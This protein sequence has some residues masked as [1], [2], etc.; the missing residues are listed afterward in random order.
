MII[1]LL[2]I[3]LLGVVDSTVNFTQEH[4]L[5][6]ALPD[7]SRATERKESSTQGVFRGRGMI[8]NVRIRA[9]GSYAY[10]SGESG[11]G[12]FYRQYTDGNL[13]SWVETAQLKPDDLPAD[14]NTLDAEGSQS[15]YAGIYQVSTTDSE[16]Q[17]IIGGR[18]GMRM[19]NDKFAI[20]GTSESK[21]FV[22][23]SAFGHSYTNANNP[24]GYA[25]L[26]QAY[27]FTGEFY[28]WTQATT[29]KF[30]DAVED[31]GYHFGRTLTVD[32]QTM[33]TAAISCTGCDPGHF[34]TGR[35]DASAAGSQGRGA[36][37]IYRGSE[38]SAFTKWT[39]T[40]K[41][42]P[43]HNKWYYFGGGFMQ[44]D[45][46]TLIADACKGAECTDDAFAS[47]EYNAPT[48]DLFV[49]VK[50]EASGLWSEQQVLTDG[51]MEIEKYSRYFTSLALHDD[52]IAMGYS[53]NVIKNTYTKG[54]PTGQGGLVMVWYPNKPNYELT[55]TFRYKAGAVGKKRSGNSA[56]LNQHQW[57]LQQ[58]LR[59]EVASSN[60][61]TYF[62]KY[63]SIS[64]D[65]MVVGARGSLSATATTQP[66]VTLFTRPRQGGLWSQ[67]QILV[68]TAESKADI[69]GAV[70][71]NN[72]FTTHGIT[73]FLQY[74]S[75]MAHGKWKCL[76]VSM[77]D[78][79]GD[80]WD[81]AKLRVSYS[82][83]T[84]DYY[85]PDCNSPNPLEFEYCPSMSHQGGTYTFEVVHHKE[86]Q[87]N[88]E[89]EWKVQMNL[90]SHKDI[91][92]NATDVYWA[93]RHSKMSFYWNPLELSFE[94]V[95]TERLI[96]ATLSC[97][98]CPDKTRT[99]HRRLLAGPD[100][101]FGEEEAAQPLARQLRHASRTASP[102]VS[103]APTMAQSA[104]FLSEWE[105]LVMTTSNP[106]QPW[107]STDRTGTYFMMS[108]LQG[109][110][111]LRQYSQ[112][113]GGTTPLTHSCW[114]N[115]PD[116]IPDGEY[117][118]RIGGARAG[119]AAGL[120]TWSF[121]GV[122]GGQLEH[123]QFKVLNGQC[124][125]VQRFTKSRFCSFREG[126]GVLA[127]MVID[128]GLFDGAELSRA[129]QQ[130]I[131]GALE[132]LVPET[133]STD[134]KISAQHRDD[135]GHLHITVSLHLKLLE[136]G[137]DPSDFAAI[138]TL[139][140]TYNAYM[141]DIA[142]SGALA[143]E[144]ATSFEATGAFLEQK[145]VHVELMKFDTAT[146]P[147]GQIDVDD[148]TPPDTTQDVITKEWLTDGFKPAS[149][150]ELEVFSALSYLTDA[151]ATCGYIGLLV[152]AVYGARAV[153]RQYRQRQESVAQ[154]LENMASAVRKTSRGAARGGA[155]RLSSV[156][157]AVLE[158]LD[159]FAD[160]VVDGEVTHDQATGSP[161]VAEVVI[162][163]AEELFVD[164]AQAHVRRSAG[165]RKRS[166]DRATAP[167]VVSGRKFGSGGSSGEEASLSTCSSESSSSDSDSSVT[168]S[169]SSRSASFSESS[170]EDESLYSFT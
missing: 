68:D 110:K 66:I 122:D 79:F 166:T 22:M 59:N 83:G 142:A 135:D 144:L 132:R 126:A 51:V 148:D 63:I 6:G 12:M 95:S 118:A 157:N 19:E 71:Y 25:E 55:E 156:K 26:G 81:T 123:L 2:F 94:E 28:H 72:V 44:M 4:Y 53:L 164:E 11:L 103:P 85:Y 111:L 100:E 39:A 10:T 8:L 9:S 90:L 43:R 162:P 47:R 153:Q 77:F 112:C 37:Y 137:Y 169:S 93:D 154:G 31:A 15:F 158:V 89:I 92:G 70:I 96:P 106:L 149:S 98:D 75:E 141:Y 14:P 124:Y 150:A 49:Y 30:P 23:V 60:Y 139:E 127:E 18:T 80:G 32:K 140:D 3:A 101:G 130:S 73:P 146:I 105:K 64:G 159:D 134:F 109:K 21:P 34:K 42:W 170:S 119:Q 102:T 54:S 160:Y 165:R 116:S 108:D 155:S 87:F 29:L 163:S 46:N 99:A 115:Y 41:L 113:G 57:S 121:C 33:D 117:I 56:S 147:H 61:K 86:A 27:V 82:D 52:T 1:L 74:Q 120:H 143:S 129:Q 45:G 104:Q 20:G 67:Q 58:F 48:T 97:R 76:V 114:T 17:T 136:H 5:T 131:F 128:L 88:W 152:C 62:G 13:G 168:S 35:V 145:N 24:N 36:I 78:E 38:A 133:K 167:A 7:G 161:L 151:I 16:K 138:S 107:F 50:Q 91:W 65:R 69:T 84:Y 40:Q 125:P